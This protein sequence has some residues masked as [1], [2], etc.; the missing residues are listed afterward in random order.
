[1]QSALKGSDKRIASFQ[2]AILSA[3]ATRP[4]EPGCGIL[5]LWATEGLHL[6]RMPFGEATRSLLPLAL[7]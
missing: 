4:C 1:M 7:D 2:A 3:D 5:A 6:T